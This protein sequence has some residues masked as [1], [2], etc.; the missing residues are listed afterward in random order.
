[1]CMTPTIETTAGEIFV[2]LFEPETL[3][4]RQQRQKSAVCEQLGQFVSENQHQAASRHQL[5]V[6]NEGPDCVR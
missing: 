5:S 2:M 1:M 6:A 4:T 3:L